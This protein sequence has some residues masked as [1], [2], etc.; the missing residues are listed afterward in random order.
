MAT[1][2]IQIPVFVEISSVVLCLCSEREGAWVRKVK[3]SMPDM[4]LQ[5]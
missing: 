3:V 2:S 1:Y 4:R 5:R